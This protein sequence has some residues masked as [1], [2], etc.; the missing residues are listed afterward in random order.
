MKFS[1]YGSAMF[2]FGT[3]LVMSIIRSIFP[4]NEILRLGIGLSTSATLLLIGKRYIN[5]IDQVFDAVRF[6]TLPRS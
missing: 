6:R 4:E 5:Y 1:I 3:V 2:N